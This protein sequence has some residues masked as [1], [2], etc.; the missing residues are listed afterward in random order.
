MEKAIWLNYDLGVGGDF[1]GL[2]SWLDDQVLLNAEII[3][4]ILDINSLTLSNLNINALITFNVGDFHD[5][6][7]AKRIDIIS[8]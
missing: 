6:C 7:K 8:Q 4:P 3:R 1:Q 2:Y 5:L